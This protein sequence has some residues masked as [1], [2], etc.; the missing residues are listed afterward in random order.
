V[1]ICHRPEG[2]LDWLK[3]LIA[4]KGP[5]KIEV[6]D[7]Y[8]EL[9]IT[10]QC[11]RG[12]SVKTTPLILDAETAELLNRL[13]PLCKTKKIRNETIILKYAGERIFG[14]GEF[15]FTDYDGIPVPPSVTVKMHKQF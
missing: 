15:I 2:T 9:T 1:P 7:A 12:L 5:L 10:V 14:D 3:D 13:Y 4:K 6:Y 8:Q 11:P